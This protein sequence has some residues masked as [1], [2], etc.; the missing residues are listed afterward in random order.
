M[1]NQISV[2]LP[3]HPGTLADFT[4]TLME[5]KIN[6][7]AIST[8]D[9]TD[10]GILRILVDKTEECLKVLKSKNF[11]V[12]VTDVIAVKV[13]DKPGG[14]YEIAA[15]LGENDVNIEYCYSTIIKEAAI[16]VFRIDDIAKA[17]KILKKKGIQ[18]LEQHEL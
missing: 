8:A 6:M 11:L 5:N 13:P 16:I 10:Y 4:K 3:N 2:F 15:F 1:L 14:L 12:T 7:R 17:I 9:T 18:L